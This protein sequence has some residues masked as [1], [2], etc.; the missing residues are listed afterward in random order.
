M[1]LPTWT[2]RRAPQTKKLSR[3][4][5][6]L[7]SALLRSAKSATYHEAAAARTDLEFCSGPPARGSFSAP[8]ADR[9]RQQRPR[10]LRE[11]TSDGDVNVGKGGGGQASRGPALLSPAP[12]LPLNPCKPSKKQKSGRCALRG[13]ILST[14]FSA[15]A[16][17]RA[18]AAATRP[19]GL[20][21]TYPCRGP[22]ISFGRRPLR[23][24]K[25]GTGHTANRAVAKAFRKPFN[26][27]GLS[28]PWASLAGSFVHNAAL[29]ISEI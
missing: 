17:G 10:L 12:P 9:R 28:L 29:T 14:L 27:S 6:R 24:I 21:N 25:G 22:G 13:A 8:T 4:N 16:T 2:S 5:T 15:S 18:R 1:E 11:N 19:P 3:K 26:A 20:C 23:P 7:S